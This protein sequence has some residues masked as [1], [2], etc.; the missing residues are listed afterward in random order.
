V[1]LQRRAEPAA[2]GVGEIVL[3]VGLDFRW[4]D[5]EGHGVIRLLALAAAAACLTGATAL[6]QDAPAVSPQKFQREFRSGEDFSARDLNAASFFQVRMNG[7]NFQNTNLSASSFEQCDLA[8]A[9]FRGAKFS[10]ESRMF[11]VTAN[12][13]N[14]EGVDFGGLAIDSVNLRDANLRGAKNFGPVQRANFQKADLRGADLS[15]LQ[16]PLVE[17][18][19]ENAVYDSNTIFPKGFDPAANG[20]VRA[21]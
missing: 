3:R 7:S 6:S 1:S 17:V 9:D 13:G 14:F 10:P 20:A 11:R 5:S 15:G 19:W 12:E 16:M 2:R 18:R 21:E 8:E 4:W